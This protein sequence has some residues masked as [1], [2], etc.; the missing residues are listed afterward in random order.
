VERS[1]KHR[2]DNTAIIR[3]SVLFAFYLVSRDNKEK[4]NVNGERKEKDTERKLA[5]EIE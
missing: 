4:K 3:A 2:R 1:D 5:R